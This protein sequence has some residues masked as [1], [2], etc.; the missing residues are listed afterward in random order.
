[1]KAGLTE[2]TAVPIASTFLFRLLPPSETLVLS[3]LN[4][5]AKV[6]KMA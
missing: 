1:M 4:I 2:N 3:F 5:Q 6:L